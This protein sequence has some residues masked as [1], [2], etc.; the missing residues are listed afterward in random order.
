MGQLPS[1]LRVGQTHLIPRPPRSPQADQQLAQD[2]VCVAFAA[3]GFVAAHVGGNAAPDGYLDAPLGPLGDPAEMRS[4]FEPGIAADR[5]SNLLWEREHGEAKR[6][7]V[8]CEPLVVAAWRE[9]VAAATTGD[10]QD[11]PILRCGD[12]ASRPAVVGRRRLAAPGNARADPSG[13]PASNRPS[14]QQGNLDRRHPQRNRH[15]ARLRRPRAA[16]RGTC[17]ERRCTRC[18]GRAHR[19]FASSRTTRRVARELCVPSASF[20]PP[21]RCRSRAG[22]S[23]STASRRARLGTACRSLQRLQGSLC[24][25]GFPQPSR[26]DAPSG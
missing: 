8:V 5:L 25:T 2:R 20:R 11:A 1:H 23:C 21:L 16:S 15:H 26:N 22:Q 13:L 19:H 12:D 17:L 9:Q 7:A 3:L 18:S 24:R 14:R 6:V 10:P 4:L